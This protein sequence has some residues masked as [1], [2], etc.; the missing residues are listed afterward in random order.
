[1]K[2]ILAISISLIIMVMAF[3]AIPAFADESDNSADTPTDPVPVQ[4][5]LIHTSHRSPKAQLLHF[6]GMDAASQD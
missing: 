3:T 6:S 2:K 1:V 5:W 4:A